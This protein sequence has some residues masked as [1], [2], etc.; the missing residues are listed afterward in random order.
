[1]QAG[2]TDRDAEEMDLNAQVLSADL[3]GDLS[4]VHRR[5]RSAE[6]VSR[7]RRSSESPKDSEDSER[8]EALKVTEVR[9]SLLSDATA[10]RVFLADSAADSA[11]SGA[12]L[13]RSLTVWKDCCMLQPVGRDLPA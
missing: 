11:G 7:D 4:V 9:D 5:A 1:M 2:R 8:A 13:S 3:T 6:K 10:D 12:D